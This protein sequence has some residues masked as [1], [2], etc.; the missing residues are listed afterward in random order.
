MKMK[1]VFETWFHPNFN[2]RLLIPFMQTPI[3]FFIKMKSV[4]ETKKVCL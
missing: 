3:N 1:S 2:L 4:F